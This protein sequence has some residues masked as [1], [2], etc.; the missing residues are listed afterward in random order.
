MVRFKER[1]TSFL[2][3]VKADT[4]APETARF[5]IPTPDPSGHLWAATL[6]TDL[7]PGVHVL[8]VRSTDEFG[9]KATAN[10]VFEVCE[11]DFDTIEKG[12]VLIRD[13]IVLTAE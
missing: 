9:N 12:Q 11:E 4:T 3:D 13:C 7:A 8:Q 10:K 1:I 6:P 2:E 5:Q